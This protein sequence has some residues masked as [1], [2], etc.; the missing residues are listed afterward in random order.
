[1][2]YIEDLD[3]KNNLISLKGGLNEEHN[4]MTILPYKVNRSFTGSGKDYESPR[5]VE[6]YEIDF[7]ELKPQPN[8]DETIKKS[9]AEFNSRTESIVKD[10]VFDEIRKGD[11][12]LH[13]TGNSYKSMY[14][15]VKRD[16]FLSLA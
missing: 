8:F 9:L 3:L 13:K 6:T 10:V 7:N 15:N 12:D 4:P 2:L 14:S 5:T 1:K 16:P 11:D